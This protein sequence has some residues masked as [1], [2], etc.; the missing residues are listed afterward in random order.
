MNMQALMQQAKKMQKDL[1]KKQEELANKHFT[2]INGMVEVEVTGDK[3]V[4]SVNIKTDDVIDADD[5]EM[6]QDMIVLAMNDAFSKADAEKEKSL[7]AYGNQFGGL[8]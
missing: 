2:G 7:G 8:F 5:R 3:K 4:L 6:L 1:E